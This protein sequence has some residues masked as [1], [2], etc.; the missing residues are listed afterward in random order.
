MSLVRLVYFSRNQLGAPHAALA[1]RVSEV[2]AVA[3]ANNRRADIS[4]GLIFS[5]AWFAQVLEGDRTAIVETFARIQRDARHGEVTTIECRLADTR[6]FGLWW[7]AAG[8]WPAGEAFAPYP[9]DGDAA[10][11][12]IHA[13]LHERMKT[14]TAGT[15]P[16]WLAG[17]RNPDAAIGAPRSRIV[18]AA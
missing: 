14:P 8:E 17:L 2:L 16:H 7:M 3:I 6:R 11:D 18:C 5:A 9:L 10:C 13:V 12:V 15:A 1:D 4:G